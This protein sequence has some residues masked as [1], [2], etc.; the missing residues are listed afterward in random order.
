MWQAIANA[1]ANGHDLCGHP[2]D[3]TITGDLS[4]CENRPVSE[5][6][7]AAVSSAAAAVRALSGTGGT[8]AV[9][10]NLVDQWCKTSVTPIGWK[11]PSQWDDFARDYATRDGWIRLHTNAPHHRT[12]AHSVLGNPKTGEEAAERISDWAGEDLETE[13]VD[14]GGCAAVRY[15]TARWRTHPQ[16]QAV[17]EEPVVAWTERSARKTPWRPTNAARPLA[18]LRVLDLT[19][20]LAGPVCTRFLAAFGA[21]VLRIDPESW[22]EEGNAVEMTVGKTCSTLDLKTE[23]GRSAFLKLAG[24]AHLMVSGYRADALER[25]GLGPEALQAA[26]PDLITVSLNAYGW[27]GPWRTRRGFDSLVQR[28]TGLAAP[29][30]DGQPKGL[31]Y[32]VL[33]HSTGYLMAAAAIHA[34][35]RASSEGMVSSARLSLARQAHLLLD[36]WRDEPKPSDFVRSDLIRRDPTFETTAWGDLQRLPLPFAIEGISA[37][38]RCPAHPLRSD[39]LGWIDEAGNSVRIT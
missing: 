20:V 10:R 34:L 33:D 21:S 26:N 9:D 24:E 1:L 6:A 25:L 22:N 32:Q 23:D 19:R 12:A 7:L 3:V 16:G 2:Q 30:P 17:A 36:H 31:P 35:L 8:A 28:S 38:W 11:L 37:S 15:D 29:G 18:G 27:T 39:P 14:A 13:I 5:L 4:L